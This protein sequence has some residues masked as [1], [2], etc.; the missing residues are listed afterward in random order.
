M[1]G[2]ECFKC[3]SDEDL[4]KFGQQLICADCDPERNSATDAAPS[5]DDGVRSPGDARQA[6]A[7]RLNDAGLSTQRFIDVHDGEKKSTNHTQYGPDSRR[8]SGNYGV[9]G[10]AGATDGDRILVDVDVDDYDGERAPDWIPE[11]FTVA[12]PHTDGDSGGHFY[13]ALPVAAKDALED[14][15]GT[16]NPSPPWGEIRIDNQYCV[17]PG[18]QL[19]G[20]TKDWCDDC[21]HEDGGY[22]HIKHDAPIAQLE[23]ETFV[24]AVVDDMPEREHERSDEAGD[25]DDSQSYADA[26]DDADLEDYEPTATTSDETTDDIRDIFAALERLDARRVA[27]DTIVHAWN[28]EATTSDGKR[29]FAP[30]WGP[31]ANGTANVVDEQIW[32]DTGGGGYGGPVTMAL[33]DAGE[34]SPQTAS[35]KVSG[36]LW[37]TGVEH[38]RDL[39]YDIPE[40]ETSTSGGRWDVETCEP[41]ARDLQ[42]FDQ[43]QRWQSLQGD[44]FDDALAHD[45][46]SLWADQPGSGKTTNAALAAIERDQS[47]VIYFDKHQK[48]REFTK[49]DPIQETDVEYY[50]LKG[51]AQKRHGQCM[52]ADHHDEECPEHGDTH[53]CPSMCPIYDL[54]PD[55]ETRQAYETLVQEVGPNKAHQILGLHED[56]DHHWHDGEC[57]WQVQYREVESER[58]IVGVHEYATQKTVRETGLNIIDETTDSFASERSYSAEQLTRLANTLEHIADV[59]SRD[60]P[61]G[62]TARQLASFARDVVDAITDAATTDELADLEPPTVTAEAYETHDDAAGA[63]IARETADEGRGLAEGL[64]NAKIELGETVLQRMQTDDWQGTPISIDPLLAAAVDA[65][66][67]REGTMQAVSLSPV[68]DGCPWCDSETTHDNGARCCVDDDCDWHEA[69]HSFIRE[70]TT[71]ARA[72]SWFRTDRDGS[73]RALGYQVLPLPDQLPTAEDTLILD[74]TGAVEKVATVFDIDADRVAKTGDEPLAMPNL[75]TTQVLDGQYHAGTI[76]QSLADDGTLASRIQRTIDTAVDV[77]ENPLFIC[78]RELIE[79]FDFPAHVDVLHY[80]ATRGLNRND[81]DAVICIGAPHPDVEDLQRDARLLAMGR[82]DVDTG[83]T[84]YSTRRGAEHDPVYRRLHYTDDQGQGRAIPTKHYDGLVGTLFR[85]SRE[86]ELVQA[87]HRIRP[88]LA[89]SPKHAYLLTNVPTTVEIDELATFEELADPLRL[90]VDIPDG[91]ID[92]LDAVRDVQEG[93]GPD[94]FRAEQLVE[95]RDDGTVA[96][97]VAEYH[98]LAR[99]SGL[100]VSKRTIYEWIHAL[101]DAGLLHPE[102]YEQRSGVS[103]AVDLATLKSALQILSNNAGFKVA[104][105]RRLTSILRESGSGL[106]WLRWAQGVFDVHGSDGDDLLPPDRGGVGG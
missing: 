82:D 65:G 69:I 15:I 81:C 30:T 20:C 100:S 11:T 36:E 91:A 38:L 59:S 72:M 31:N 35:P 1:T 86:K 101:E 3:G 105:K 48:A 76:K 16:A 32:Q 27:E 84:E 17:G 94:G 21:A 10:G 103:Y 40:L 28:P 78:K 70:S 44:R 9:Y 22:Y 71:P 75:H 54:D 13:L 14:R 58:F 96:N 93:H 41:P 57:P 53:E 67:D 95:Q 102:T 73:R 49:D 45:G 74:A 85:E 64:A 63:H 104:A 88:L 106:D 18:S 12:S 46:I 62:Y 83:G 90:M 56:D 92:L 79:E 25:L 98:R 2:R 5:D 23:T 61:A 24:E 89:D 19:D 26:F 39:G 33:I 7:R 60:E 68:I 37:W 6:F 87:L 50:H 29:A 43:E 77:H 34:L 4:Q 52:D 55:H 47:H 97:K 99:L 51:G 66:L 80:H 42:P 8:L